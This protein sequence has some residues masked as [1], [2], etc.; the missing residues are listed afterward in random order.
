[1][2]WLAFMI[3]TIRDNKTT[4]A[5]GPS[6]RALADAI[7]D[8]ADLPSAKTIVEY[9]PGEGVF[10]EAILR[11]KSA[12]S[13]FVAL[14][15]LPTL[16]EATKKRCP[17]VNVVQ[18]SA[19]NAIVYLRE[20]GYDNCDAIVSGLPWARFPED[21]QDRLLD[22][23]FKVLAPGG[24]FVTFAYAM[25]PAIPSGRRFF[26][27]KMPEKFGR[28]RRVGPVWKNLPPCFVYIATKPK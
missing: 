14:E 15:V 8:L 19:E 25:S 13:F 28:I 24:R 26:S 9:G 1:M 7:T 4:G 27:G 20:A 3:E 6:S 5:F 12:D 17:G 16:V 10:T 2:S 11:K 21:L 18:D 22:A 23:T